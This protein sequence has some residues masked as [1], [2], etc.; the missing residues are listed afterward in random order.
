MEA[1]WSAVECVGVVGQC[2]GGRSSNEPLWRVSVADIRH[3]GD[4][5]EHTARWIALLARALLVWLLHHLTDSDRE[6][7]HLSLHKETG[8]HKV[9]VLA[10]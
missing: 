7:H 2:R 3:I 8:K 9:E 1:E 6:D 4:G 5:V 10:D